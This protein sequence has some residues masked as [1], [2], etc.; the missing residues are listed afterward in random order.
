MWGQAIRFIGTLA[1]G[2]WLNDFGAFVAKALGPS[3]AS[4]VVRE[5]GKGFTWWFVLLIAGAL[6]LIVGGVAYFAGTMLD[7]KTS[8]RRRK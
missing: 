7:K 4:K 2:Y 6:A 3:T 8:K 1:S 5:D